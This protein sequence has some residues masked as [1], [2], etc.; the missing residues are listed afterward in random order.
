MKTTLYFSTIFKKQNTISLIEAFKSIEQQI[1]NP[2]GYILG[3]FKKNIC[4]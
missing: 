4:I 2:S 3:I 1:S